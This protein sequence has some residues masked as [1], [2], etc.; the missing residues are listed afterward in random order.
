[1]ALRQGFIQILFKS[2][3][4]PFQKN[5]SQFIN[6][7]IEFILSQY[8]KLPGRLVSEYRPNLVIKGKRRNPSP[9]SGNFNPNVW[10]MNG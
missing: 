10:D 8:L 4:L 9:S 3:L 7:G 5:L 6:Y 2:D 1:M